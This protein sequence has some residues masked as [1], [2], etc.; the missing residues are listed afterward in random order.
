VR[1][2]SILILLPLIWL[3]GFL[4]FTRSLPIVAEDSNIHTDAIVVLTGSPGRISEGLIL[5]SY[6]KADKLFISGIHTGTN[7]HKLYELKELSQTDNGLKGRI[8]LGYKATNTKGNAQ[9]TADWMKEN[10]YH[11]MRLVTSNY[12][13][14]RSLFEFKQLMP[15]YKIIPHPTFSQNVNVDTFWKSPK[16]IK[17]LIIEYNKYL[18]VFCLSVKEMVV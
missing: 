5:L 2:I 8:N 14:T 6:N 18:Y 4:L 15:D 16:T 12:H 7:L 3:I 17:F 9:E 10:N 13:M 11:T 1:L